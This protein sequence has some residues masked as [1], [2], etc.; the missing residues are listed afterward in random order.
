MLVFKGKYNVALVYIDSI[1]EGLI[2]QIYSMLNNPAFKGAPIILMPDTHAG[3][4][5]CVGFTWRMNE[6]IIPN[7]VGVN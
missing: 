4:G 2:S 3:K 5:A 6:Y 1:E 7:I